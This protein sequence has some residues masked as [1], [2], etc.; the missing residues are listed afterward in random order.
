MTGARRGPRPPDTPGHDAAPARAADV[1]GL[2]LAGGDGVRLQ[3]LTRRLTGTPIPKQYCRLVGDRSM[4][5]ATFARTAALLAPARTLALV[6]REHL[7]V[8]A[9]QLRS[10]PPANVLVQPRNRDTGPGVLFAALRLRERSPGA[11]VAVFPS[12]HFVRDER[13]FLAYVAR[14]IALVQ[15]FPEKIVLLGMTPD[16]PEPGLGY[17]GL[18]PPPAGAAGEDVF[19][20]A[21]FVEKP[22]P[23][24][25][26]R[27]V[28]RGALWNS[29]VMLFRLETMLS[30]LRRSRPFYHEALGR[31][32]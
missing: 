17:L 14:G 25:A 29:L 20:V 19:Q 30:L 8:A 1:W 27:L 24:G 18:G 22:S 28:R 32:G 6:N 5:E 26:E 21:A 7:P 9:D 12:D 13:S 11:T 23:E 31:L 4:L 16:R 10:L 3:G 15:R 2:V